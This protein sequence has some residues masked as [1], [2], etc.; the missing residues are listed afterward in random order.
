M[1]NLQ[2][3]G[4]SS[5]I[6]QIIT[7]IVIVLLCI[8]GGY[9]LFKISGGSRPTSQQGAYQI[10]YSKAVKVDAPRAVEAD[11]HVEGNPDAKN[12]FIA[13]E[14]FECPYCAQYE[15]TV[16]SKVATELKDTK[17]VFRHYPLESIHKNTMAAAEASEAAGAQG[18]FWEMHNLLF[19][20]QNEW[21][22]LADPMPKFVEYAQA[23]GVLN[24]DQFKS[25]VEGRK[26]L[27]RISKDALEATGLDLTGT[28]TYF[29]NGVKLNTTGDLN[30]VK[31]QVEKLYK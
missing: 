21:A 28:P 30:S 5:N 7:I 19:Q 9:Y 10:D 16:T 17:F 2:T 31:Q 26:Y 4:E 18:K 6:K 3:D 11:D 29:F 1:N 22:E 14:D 8:G 23:S 15:G 24:I 27:D 20:K 13:Y 12:T 25:E